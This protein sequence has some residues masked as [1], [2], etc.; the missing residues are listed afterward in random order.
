[1]GLA[2]PLDE[3][4]LV[5]EPLRRSEAEQGIPLIRGA[6]YSSYSDRN[7]AGTCGRA[8]ELEYLLGRLRFLGIEVPKRMV[9]DIL[10]S[11]E[12]NLGTREFNYD[13]DGG[14]VTISDCRHRMLARQAA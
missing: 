12:M 4:F 2:W 13:D 14:G 5:V 3:Y 6:I 8:P 9:D 1:M 10:A 11:H 7:L